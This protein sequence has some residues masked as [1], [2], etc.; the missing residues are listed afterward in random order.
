[1]LIILNIIYTMKTIFIIWQ[2]AEND[3]NLTSVPIPSLMQAKAQYYVIEH[4]LK[5]LEKVSKN[6]SRT[7]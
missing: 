1:M 7:A 2:M 6:N 5:S 3:F 4:K